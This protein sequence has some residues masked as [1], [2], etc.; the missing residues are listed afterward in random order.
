MSTIRHKSKITYII[1]ENVLVNMMHHFSWIFEFSAK[2][3][4]HYPTMLWNKSSILIEYFISLFISTTRTSF[5][6]FGLKRITS[7]IKS[8]KVHLTKKM[9][10]MWLNAVF[11]GAPP[12]MLSFASAHR[13]HYMAQTIDLSR[14]LI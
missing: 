1:V 14:G 3:L 12:I 5:S 13:T 4:F 8:H 7:R 6:N 10:F 9:T 2:M 11:Y